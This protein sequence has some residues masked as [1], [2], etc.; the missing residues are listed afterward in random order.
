MCPVGSGQACSSPN[1][2]D[3]KGWAAREGVFS[4]FTLTMGDNLLH[5]L[6]MLN[7][8][9]WTKLNIPPEPAGICR[10]S[11]ERASSDN[12]SRREFGHE[13]QNFR[14]QVHS[15]PRAPVGQFWGGR[16][17]SRVAV[18]VVGIAT[19]AAITLFL[20]R[21]SLSGT[22]ERR[23]GAIPYEHGL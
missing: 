20:R 6:A 10:A 1:D 15:R 2:C 9:L 18:L 7:A 14:G 21:L 16:M 4:D 3:T 8:P 22:A 13:A 5:T 17:K 19:V 11:S 12:P 23:H